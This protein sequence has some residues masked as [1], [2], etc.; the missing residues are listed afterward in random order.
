MRSFVRSL[1][2]AL[3]KA[4]H[5]SKQSPK[6]PLRMS[7]SGMSAAFYMATISTSSITN[8]VPEEAKEKRHHLKDGKGFTNPWDSWRNFSGPGILKAMVWYIKSPFAFLACS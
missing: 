3:K 8:A 7:N 6:K 5:S 2:H 1:L 4:K